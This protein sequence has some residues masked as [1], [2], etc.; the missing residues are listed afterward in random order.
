MRQNTPY[1][2]EERVELLASLLSEKKFLDLASLLNRTN[3]IDIEEFIS[4]LSDEDA[5]IVFRLLKKDD[6]A[7]VFAELDHDQ[8][9][10]LLSGITDLEVDNIFKDLNFDDMIDTLEEMPAS[11]VKRV[12]TKI[13]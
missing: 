6:A 13:G 5:V 4:S 11:F 9:Q 3:P 12:L 1:N 7:E 8:K 10:K 2:F